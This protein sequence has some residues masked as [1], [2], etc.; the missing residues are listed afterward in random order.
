VS[1]LDGSST[2]ATEDYCPIEAYFY[3]IELLL[4][5]LLAP[6]LTLLANVALY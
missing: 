6:P 4:S 2:T 1:H 3:D 5:C